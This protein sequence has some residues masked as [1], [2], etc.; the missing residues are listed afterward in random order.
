MYA[1]MLTAHHAL[2]G[3]HVLPQSIVNASYHCPNVILA[4]PIQVTSCARAIRPGLQLGST[5]AY[6]HLRRLVLC[7]DILVQHQSPAVSGASTTASSQLPGGTQ[8]FD[9][10]I[11]AWEALAQAR[12]LPE[13][14]AAARGDAP[15][16]CCKPT[17][18]AWACCVPFGPS[19]SSS[20]SMSGNVSGNSSSVPGTSSSTGSAGPGSSRPGGTSHLW[21]KAQRQVPVSRAVAELLT[22]FVQLMI[23]LVQALGASHAAGGAS[24]GAAGDSNKQQQQAQRFAAVRQA[25]YQQLL[26]LELDCQV[27]YPLA[28]MYGAYVLRDMAPPIVA[29]LSKP[30]RPDATTYEAW[31]ACSWLQC[32]Q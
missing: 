8:S 4:C 25:L 18:S 13:L 11:V 24:Q 12:V 22:G 1:C 31:L 20:S 7:T 19:S 32:I 21:P 2:L 3:M 9:Q 30:V 10:D 26:E 23:K 5:K 27:N 28:V 16:S 15:C 17:A 6:D 29:A 14:W